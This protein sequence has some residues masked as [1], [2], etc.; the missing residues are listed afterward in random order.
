MVCLTMVTGNRNNSQYRWKSRIL[1]W[2]GLTDEIT[3]KVYHGYGHI[4][5]LVIYGHVLRLGPLPR[6]RYTKS[7]LHNTLALLRLFMVKP[8]GGA[9][10][11]TV[12]EGKVI[13]A[14]S[15]T[16]GFF[17]LEWKDNPPLEVG[18]HEVKVEMIGQ[19]DQVLATGAGSLYIPHATQ[20]GFI[21]DIDDT[22][23][24]SHSANLH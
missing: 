12:W 21:S 4:N 24:I 2:F 23:L 5:H 13:E 15:D 9:R 1:E 7:I 18:W 22:F 16:D 19:A 20:Y 11:R 8:L 10:I 17:K 14:K 6:R 3:I